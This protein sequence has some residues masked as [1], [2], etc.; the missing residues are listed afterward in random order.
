MKMSRDLVVLSHLRWVF[1]WQRPQHLISRIG[2]GFDRTWF[3]E[4]P[5]PGDGPE[6]QL[7]IEDHGQVVRVVIE[8][9]A[10]MPPV[11]FDAWACEQYAEAI[12]RLLG[13]AC[14]ST[15]WLYTPMALDVAR[16][17]TPSMLVYD[18]MDDLAAFKNAAPELVLR[19]RQ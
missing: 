3:V 13:P 11:G 17:L 6:P 7:R 10:H 14:Q 2:G 15:V 16:S 1:V 5:M 19:Q 12:P 9:P 18:V 4:E 8:L